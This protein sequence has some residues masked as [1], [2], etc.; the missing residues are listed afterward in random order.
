VV[1]DL[2]D[3]QGHSLARPHVGDLA[4]PAIYAPISAL[5]ISWKTSSQE[6]TLDSGVGNLR[7]DAGFCVKRSTI[8][9]GVSFN[10]RLHFGPAEPSSSHNTIDPL[11]RA[12]GSE[13]VLLTVESS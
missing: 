6:R 10:S 7:H 13:V 8:A 1:K 4:E 11:K 3:P 12:W 5:L 9:P 2:L